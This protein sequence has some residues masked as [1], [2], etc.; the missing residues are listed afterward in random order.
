MEQEI[1]WIWLSR[2]PRIQVRQVKELGKVYEN[3][4]ALWQEKNEKALQ[5]QNI[6]AI[7]YKNT[8]SKSGRGDAYQSGVFDNRAGDG[9]GG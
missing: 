9:S 8:R 1:Y 7:L 2:L 5:L 6:C 4:E 3:L